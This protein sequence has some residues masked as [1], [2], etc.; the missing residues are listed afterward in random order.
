MPLVSVQR[1]RHSTTYH[2]HTH[3]S[4]HL[5]PAIVEVKVRVTKVHEAILHH[6]I[7]GI[8]QLRLFHVAH[9]VVPAVV[10]VD[11]CAVKMKMKR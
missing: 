3:P 9:P 4:S 10:P 8:A 1:E 2:E 6:R 5:G 11:T 7:N